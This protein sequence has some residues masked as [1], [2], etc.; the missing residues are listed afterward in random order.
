MFR[1]EPLKKLLQQ[2]VS[3]FEFDE[4]FIVAVAFFIFVGLV[5]KKAK[6]FIISGVDAR[7]LKV[8]SE[9]EEA[10]RLKSEAQALY[11]KA[12]NEQNRSLE[13]VQGIL[14]H[15]RKEAERITGEAKEIL[16][17]AL[18]KRTEL[19]MQKIAQ[20]EVAVVADLR[21]NALDITMDAARTLILESMSREVAEEILSK[22]FQDIDRKMVH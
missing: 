7:I 17:F 14:A 22:A 19:A 16:E 20:A 18:N 3:M 6:S 9:L 8:K 11:T 21:A 10:A 15:A 12:Q 4:H 2:G 13:E 1:A 5:Y